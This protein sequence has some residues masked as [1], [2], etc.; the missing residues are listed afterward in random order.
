MHMLF[1]P[2]DL[3]DIKTVLNVLIVFLVVDYRMQRTCLVES[4]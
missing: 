2:I 4:L 1:F 3:F